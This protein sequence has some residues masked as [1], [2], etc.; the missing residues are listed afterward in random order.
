MATITLERKNEPPVVQAV[1]FMRWSGPVLVGD[2]PPVLYEIGDFFP[3]TVANV[4]KQ[5]GDKVLRSHSPPDFYAVVVRPILDD[6]FLLPSMEPLIAFP[7]I[8]GR[9]PYQ[10]NIRTSVVFWNGEFWS[11]ALA[12]EPE[13]E[14]LF[15]SIYG[16]LDKW[17]LD[18]LYK[19]EADKVPPILDAIGKKWDDPATAPWAI[20]KTRI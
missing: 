4:Q 6:A 20:P 2:R 3:L 10:S 8:P 14:E 15:V 18:V 17:G 11:P 7:P 16:K 1:R 12:V 5:E 9:G 19:V 13:R